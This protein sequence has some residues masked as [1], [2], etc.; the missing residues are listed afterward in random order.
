VSG[1][2]VYSQFE[3]KVINGV[4]KIV[5]N[6]NLVRGLYFVTLTNKEGY[7]SKKFIY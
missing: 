3:N 2:V 6:V 1:K 7:V 5:M 4:N